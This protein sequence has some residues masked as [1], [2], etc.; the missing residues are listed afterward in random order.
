MTRTRLALDVSE[1]AGGLGVLVSVA[2]VS[3]PLMLGQRSPNLSTRRQTK[4]QPDRARRERQCERPT[5]QVTQPLASAPHGGEASAHSSQGGQRRR[6]N[7]EP[8]AYGHARPDRGLHDRAPNGQPGAACADLDQARRRPVNLLDEPQKD[9]YPS[10]RSRCRTS[11]ELVRLALR[12]IPSVFARS[13]SRIGSRR[14][15]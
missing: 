11:L 9:F 15:W 1:S 14:V 5:R 4:V 7:P 13:R 6:T 8:P 12:C 2:L 10:D 3:V